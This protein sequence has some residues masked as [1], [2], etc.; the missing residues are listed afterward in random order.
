MFSGRGRNAVLDNELTCTTLH[1]EGD[2][3]WLVAANPEFPDIVPKD[4]QEL[5]IWGVVTSCIKSFGT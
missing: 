2:R 4:G 3:V 5:V 1:R